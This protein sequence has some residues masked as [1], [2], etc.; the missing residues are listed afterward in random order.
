VRQAAPRSRRATIAPEAL[1]FVVAL[2]AR[3]WVVLGDGGFGGNFYYDP[4]VYYGAAD[5]LTHGRMPY[6][7]YVL[8]HPPLIAIVTAPF[9]L[10]GRLTTDHTGFICGNLAYTLLAAGNAVLVLRVA[11]RFGLPRHAAIAGALTYAV[12]TG[13]ITAEFLIRLEPLGNLFLLLA[14]AAVATLQRVDTRLPAL[15]CGALLGCLI[16]VKIWWAVPIAVIVVWQCHTDRT[17]RRGLVMIGGLLATCVVIDVPFLVVAGARMYRSI[18][19]AQLQ[20]TSNHV[21]VHTRLDKLAGLSQLVG[22]RFNDDSIASRAG[23]QALVVAFCCLGVATCIQALRTPLGRA[24]VIMLGLELVVFFATQTWFYTYCDYLAVP[25]ALTVAVA[26]SRARAPALVLPAF[27]FVTTVCTFFNGGLHMVPPYSGAQR[28]ARGVT[29]VRCVVSDT[30]MTLIQLNALDRSFTGGCRNWVDLTGVRH[31][32]GPNPNDRTTPGQVN[33]T[34]SKDLCTY[35]TSGD[36]VI[37]SA[38]SWRTIS[39]QCAARIR[40][41]P[42]IVRAGDQV[43]YRMVRS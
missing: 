5:A 37:I 28:L 29:D 15:A 36:A 4:A 39:H 24:M 30:P 1:V 10:I 9:A 8:V 38:A 41:S 26:A 22:D 14:L 35:L 33:E 21:S 43:V 7:D 40:R 25:L 27:A 19:T 20:R 12:W 17:V 32:A 42:V 23:P 11:Q 6:H 31:G 2:L 34:W 16:N 13:A 18:V 3:L